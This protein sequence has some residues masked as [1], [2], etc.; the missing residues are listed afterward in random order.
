MWTDATPQT[1]KRE[2][3]SS[4]TS[5]SDTIGSVMAYKWRYAGGKT[6]WPLNAGQF[7]EKTMTRKQKI[8]RYICLPIILIVLLSLV[9]AASSQVVDPLVSVSEVQWQPQGEFIL[10]S[11]RTADNDYALWLYDAEMQVIAMLPA[12]N[13][14]S[15]NWSPD[16]TRFAMGRNIIDVQTLETIVTVNAE[17][18]IGGWNTDGSQVLAWADDNQLGLFDATTGNIIRTIS[19]GDE[20]PD[21]IS[22]S[23]NSAYLALVLPTGVTRIIGTENGQLIAELP[24]EYPIGLRWSPDST[25]IAAGFIELVDEGIPN[26]LPFAAEPTLASIKVWDIVTSTQIH[27]FSGLPEVP[28]RIRWNPQWPELVGASADGLIYIWSLQSGQQT[29][30]VRTTSHLRSI[31]YSPFGGRLII[32]SANLDTPSFPAPVS[33]VRPD[34]SR[35]VVSNALQIVIPQL[36]IELLESV[37]T[38]CTPPNI[39]DDV[40]DTRDALQSI[41]DYIQSVEQSNVFSDGCKADLLEIAEAFRT[42]EQ[43]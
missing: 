39:I 10:V 5:R 3:M 40:P 35:D 26:T 34:W 16:G 38:A 32:G 4:I 12:E 22:W 11:G 28:I 31:E 14:F 43:E 42:Q 23:P 36:S 19:V 21:V 41:E 1:K 25:Q 27:N 13:A 15:I 33:A 8:F 17:S 20:F 7:K 9:N 30:L 37:Q 18:G 29:N 2:P 6:F 24:I